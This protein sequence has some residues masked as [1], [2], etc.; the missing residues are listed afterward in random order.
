MQFFIVNHV[1]E[2]GINKF[3]GEN[4]S[5]RNESFGAGSNKLCNLLFVKCCKNLD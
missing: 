5:R 2:S 1:Q 3:K 4:C